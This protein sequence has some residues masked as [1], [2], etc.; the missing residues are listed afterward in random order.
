MSDSVSLPAQACDGSHDKPHNKLS[1]SPVVPQDEEDGL[2]IVFSHRQLLAGAVRHGRAFVTYQRRTKD[3]KK[4][5]EKQT[6]A[7]KLLWA[8]ACQHGTEAPVSTEDQGSLH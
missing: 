5:V 3:D 8:S 2:H 4:Q 6:Q 7:S 1:T